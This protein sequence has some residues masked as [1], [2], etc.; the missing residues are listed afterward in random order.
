MEDHKNIHMIL[1]EK[2]YW[3]RQSKWINYNQQIKS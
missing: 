1:M 3:L 2:L